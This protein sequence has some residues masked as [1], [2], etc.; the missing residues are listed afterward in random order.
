MTVQGPGLVHTDNVVHSLPSLTHLESPSPEAPNPGPRETQVPN[1]C[2]IVSYDFP[3]G[4]VPILQSRKL[5][6]RELTWLVWWPSFC[7]AGGPSP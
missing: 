5:R 6:F 1:L 7:G 4:N 2:C 3:K